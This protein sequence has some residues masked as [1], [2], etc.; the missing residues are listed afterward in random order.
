MA[1]PHSMDHRYHHVRLDLPYAP[2]FRSSHL[3]GS[4]PTGRANARPMDRLER[5]ISVPGAAVMEPKGRGVLDTPHAGVDGLWRRR[6]P[7]GLWPPSQG[8]M[9]AEPGEFHR[10]HW[11]CS[12]KR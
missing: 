2:L 8:S 12:R 3:T 11:D 6:L 5:V 4:A 1:A 9:P 7:A 10:S